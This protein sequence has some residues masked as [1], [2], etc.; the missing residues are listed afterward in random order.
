MK[1][2]QYEHLFFDLDHTLWDFDT[3]SEATLRD[4]YAELKLDEKA[5]GDFDQFHKIYCIK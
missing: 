4:L 1:A 5:T 2:K 3:N